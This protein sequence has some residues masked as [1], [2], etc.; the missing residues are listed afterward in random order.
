MTPR[1]ASLT[2]SFLFALGAL[3]AA[4]HQQ[5]VDPFIWFDDYGALYADEDAYLYHAQ[6]EGRWLNYFWTLRSWPTDAR[7]LVGIY[8]ASLLVFAT[9]FAHA[10]LPLTAGLA[11]RALL[12][13]SVALFPSLTYHAFWPGT[14]A[15][16]MS[17]LAVFALCL[18]ALPP[19]RRVRA[20][21]PMSAI[22]FLSYPTYPFL[23]LP[24]ALAGQTITRRNF[25]KWLSLPV[26]AVV[27]GAGLVALLGAVFLG[28]STVEKADWRK[29]DP[30]QPEIS[31]VMT[32]LEYPGFLVRL[33]LQDITGGAIWA[34]A[35]LFL[36]VGAALAQTHRARG[37]GQFVVM[38][39]AVI[40]FL[41]AVR[42]LLE[43]KVPHNAAAFIWFI[44]AP[45]VAYAGAQSLR[46]AVVFRAA[47]LVLCGY[48]G[49]QTHQNYQSRAVWQAE[50][51][52]L[53]EA[54]RDGQK[55]VLLV[56][57]GR[58]FPGALDGNVFPLTI[59]LRIE[60]LTGRAASLCSHAPEACSAVNEPPSDRFR[61]IEGP[62]HSYVI[63]PKPFPTAPRR[64]R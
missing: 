29:L 17:V 50:T 40:G 51:R 23:L 4:F 54:L 30:E 20:F 19:Q 37:T 38:L 57:D 21:V 41:T 11:Q 16:G 49:W 60:Y 59:A 28:S 58:F 53:V 3:L 27:C 10:V 33:G 42:L 12:A 22:L 2:V 31:F 8:L 63:M 55:P 39:A 18:S 64:G 61:V 13:A 46:G 56:G 47:L 45:L 1:L 32:L 5:L 14:L 44:L 52:A 34:Q 43:V 25:A 9:V 35:A 7:I 48:F 24:I 36:L 26:L 15:L 6:H 62:G